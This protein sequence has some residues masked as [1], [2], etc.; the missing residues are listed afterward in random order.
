VCNDIPLKNTAAL[1][2]ACIGNTWLFENLNAPEMVALGETALRRT[3][4]EGEQIFSQGD[5]VDKMFLVK[6]GLVKLSKVLVDGTEITLDMRKGGDLLGENM[7]SEDV[8]YPVSAVCL[9]ETLICGF[10]RERFES[11]VLRYPRIGL[12]VMKNLSKRISSLT[13][14]VES[15]SLT[16]LENRLY[17]TLLNVALEYGTKAGD[18]FIIRFPL[19]HEDLGFLVGAHRVSVTRAMK[20]LRNTGTVLQQK[21]ALVLKIRET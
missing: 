3:Y 9:E 21:K 7:L 14:R 15:M 18:G 8:E 19:T 12:Q 11:L 4:E 2:P 13:H 16:G 6:A 17:Q 5:N 10:T 1:S 20:E